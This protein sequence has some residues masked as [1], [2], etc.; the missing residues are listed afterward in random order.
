[1][2]AINVSII[3][4]PSSIG[5]GIG[6]YDQ[7]LLSHLQKL[8]EIQINQGSPDLVH[9]T[10]FDLFYPT[11]PSPTIPT[12]VTVHDVTPLVL[13]QSYPKGLRGRINLFRQKLNLKKVAAIIT[14]SQNSKK[15]IEKHLN[16]PSH[17]IHA[18]LL[19]ADPIY[20]QTVSQ[21]FMQKVKKRYHLPDQFILYVG[22][23]NPN[24][25]LI[26]LIEAALSLSIPLVLVGSEFTKQIVTNPSVKS[27]LGLQS[28]HPELKEAVKIRT[29]IAQSPS[30]FTTGFVPS[31]QLAA[32]Y[33]LASVYCQPSIYEGFGFPLLEAMSANCLI[34]SSSVSSL[35]EIYP[36]NTITFD[37]TDLSSIKNALHRAINLEPKEK[38]KMIKQALIYSKKFTWEKT[39]KST[40]DVYKQVLN[41]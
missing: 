7:H 12:I 13:P 24:K 16:I 20:Q 31:D 19:A 30:I 25:N 33:R 10:F 41:K 37:P 23:I 17:K 14:D 11:L 32:I 6:F 15:D 18:V 34:A 40:L 1:M 27:R 38:Q 3:T 21:S 36:K 5:R 9:Y 26:H 8:P 39:A 28:I 2:T 29:L 22:G 35:P 4:H